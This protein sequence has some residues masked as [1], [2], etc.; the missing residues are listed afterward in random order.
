[1]TGRESK[2]E[3]PVVAT[4]PTTST[5]PLTSIGKGAAIVEPAIVAAPRSMKTRGAAA[6][7]KAAVGA[8]SA[9]VPA[10]ICAPNSGKSRVT[11]RELKKLTE[12]ELEEKEEA[13]KVFKQ[14]GM[15]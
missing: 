3:T 12:M 13:Q 2:Q 7:K 4:T 9:S 14:E 11:R 15:F 6:K 8:A 1:M 5:T 10:A